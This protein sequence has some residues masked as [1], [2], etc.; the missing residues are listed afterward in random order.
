MNINIDGLNK[1]ELKVKMAMNMNMNRN[2]VPKFKEQLE[3]GSLS[4]NINEVHSMYKLHYLLH[5][6]ITINESLKLNGLVQWSTCQPHPEYSHIKMLCTSEAVCLPREEDHSNQSY[7]TNKC[8]LSPK[9]CSN[10]KGNPIDYY[11]GCSV[12]K[13]LRHCPTQIIAWPKW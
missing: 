4:I 6:K 2:I 10:C 5:R 13:E 9:K 8:N 11:I 7:S 3:P 12:D 1:N